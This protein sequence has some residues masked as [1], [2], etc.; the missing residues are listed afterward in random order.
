M[1]TSTVNLGRVKGDAATIAIGTVTMGESGSDPIVNNVGDS[2]DAILD[3]TIPMGPVGPQP[4]ITIV[5]DSTNSI[6]LSDQNN[7][8]IIRCTAAD[9]VLV[10]VPSTLATGFSCMV[11]QAGTGLVTF[12][13]GSGATLNSFGNLFTTAGQ[14]APASIIHVGAGVYNL[15]GNL[16]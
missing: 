15:S 11:I 2:G 4:S 9:S 1:P 12:Q 7:N 10:T 13:G 6:T 3:F 14:H 5:N 8:A 16:V